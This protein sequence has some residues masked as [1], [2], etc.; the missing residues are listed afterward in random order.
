MNKWVL[1]AV[2]IFL[3]AAPG[4]GQNARAT[5]IVPF[6]F[7]VGQTALP[8]GTY[9]VSMPL[10]SNS[11]IQLTSTTSSAYA[12]TSNIDVSLPI[13]KFHNETSNL[14]FVRENGRTVLHQI[15]IVGQD[16]GHDL[17]HEKGLPEPK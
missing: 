12:R 4:Y 5:I 8:A 11:V 16:H 14:V 10:G 7:T 13:G 15:W 9:I 6:E 17:I 1:I 2:L 3:I